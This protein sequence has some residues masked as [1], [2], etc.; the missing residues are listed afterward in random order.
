VNQIRV[1]RQL[2]KTPGFTNLAEIFETGDS[3]ILVSE[4]TRGRRLL[5]MI[6]EGVLTDLDVLL[7]VRSLLERLA[8]LNQLQIMHRNVKPNNIVVCM[9]EN[10]ISEVIM[11]GFGLAARISSSDTI[12]KCGTPGFIA[13]EIY[14]ASEAAYSSSCDVFSAGVLFYIL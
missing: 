5:D 9:N 3:L 12:T 1:L 2:S 7:I 11:H 10:G 4:F 8:T 6:K 13:P 14:R